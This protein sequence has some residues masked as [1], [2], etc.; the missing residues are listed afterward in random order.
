MEQELSQFN[1]WWEGDYTA[2]GFRRDALEIMENE[3]K[4]RH[5]TILTGLRRVGKTYLIYQTIEQL[6]KTGVPANCI[7]YVSLEHPVIAGQGI[8]KTVEAM[9]KLH[10]HA[11][12]EKLYLFFD[13]IMYVPDFQR[14][15]KIL[16]DHENVKIIATGSS[17]SMLND[18]KAFL[19]GRN[20][21]LDMSPL[22]FSEY[23]RFRNYSIRKSEEYMLEKN[24]EEYMQYGGMPEYVLTRDPENITSLVKDILMKDIVAKYVVKEQKVIEELFLLL[25]ERVGKPV[26]YNKLANILNVKPDT[27][28]AYIGYMESTYL[29]YVIPRFSKSL[30]ERISSPKKVYFGDVGIRNVFTGFRDL[31]SVYEN[32]VFLKIKEMQPAYYFHNGCELDFAVGDTIIEAKYGRELNEKQKAEMRNSKFREKIIADGYKYFL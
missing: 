32:L 7:L 28:K 8:L 20:R 1:P 18:S 14:E 31:G 17:A 30:N 24:F 5:I 26:T 10:G 15:L 13:E 21:A 9:R 22:T 4:A 2:P 12:P 6:I 3:C 29:L 23:L 25:C 16:H 11:R 27:V 19:T